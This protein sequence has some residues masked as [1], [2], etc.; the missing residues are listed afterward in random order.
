MAASDLIDR[1]TVFVSYSQNDQKLVDELSKHLKGLEKEGLIQAWNSREIEA[2][3]NLEDENSQRIDLADIILLLISSDFICSDYYDGQHLQ[4]IVR[5]HEEESIRVIPIILRPYDWQAGTPFSNLSHLPSGEDAITEWLNQDAAFRSVSQGIRSVVQEIKKR[6]FHE[7]L[8][9]YR[10]A[11]E[12]AIRKEFPISKLTRSLLQED[13]RLSDTDVE[14]I[15]Y[16]INNNYSDFLRKYQNFISIIG[17]KN[18]VLWEVVHIL[19]KK[20]VELNLQGDLNIERI[21]K[22][23]LEQKEEEYEGIKATYENSFRK[24]LEEHGGRVPLPELIRSDLNQKKTE[25]KLLDSDASRIES[26]VQSE[27]GV[28]SKISLVTQN[29]IYSV[30]RNY[31]LSLI[32][33][34]GLLLVIICIFAAKGLFANR[35]NQGEVIDLSLVENLSEQDAI[36]LVSQW[37][38]SKRQIFGSEFNHEDSYN[39]VNSLTIGSFRDSVR[40]EL[41]K[42]SL[43]DYYYEFLEPS[44]RIPEGESGTSFCPPIELSRADRHSKGKAEIHLNVSQS[45]TIIS[46]SDNTKKSEDTNNEYAFGLMFDDSDGRWKVNTLTA[47]ADDSDRSNP[48]NLYSFRMNFWRD[49]RLTDPL[50]YVSYC[51]SRN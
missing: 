9:R 4:E 5:R 19:N 47:A 49:P 25:L 12:K 38:Y 13:E 14:D 16:S 1:V 3:L 37:F 42:M 21:E 46:R 11:Y 39:L 8:E 34:G 18:Y 32:P 43:E 2:G 10:K 41:E 31:K 6:R 7:K 51:P 30:R 27:F 45:F 20:H 22:P 24:A 50:D 40:N 26:S 17:N 33:M 48:D 15:E 28:F 35:N 36:N 29:I 23:I 44:V